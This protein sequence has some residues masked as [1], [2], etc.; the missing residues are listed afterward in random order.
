MSLKRIWIP[1]PNF[2]SRGGASVRLL[3][4]HTA[5]GAR[6]YSDLG[7]YFQG[8]VEASS[9]VG[10]D[11]TDGVIGEYVHRQ[12]KAWTCAQYNPV[13]VNVE[14]CAFSSWS[15]AEWDKHQNMLSNCARWIREEADH[16]GIPITALSP[17]AA[18]GSGR[19]VCQ[20]KDLGSA[21]GGHSDCGPA[22]P[23]DYVLQLARGDTP[24]TPEGTVGISATTNADGRVEVFVILDTGEV[25]HAYQ[26]A[27]GGAWAGS[28]EG[29]VCEW[30]SMGKVK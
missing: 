29:K 17:E 18:R 4:L 23:I 21:G 30:Y 12:D 28:K 5:E 2:S 15:A 27:A 24:P 1:S 20:H 9:H 11:D 25:K 19:G 14:L 6:T 7:H 3:V 10:I 16:Y 13:S 26:K 22:F 8:N